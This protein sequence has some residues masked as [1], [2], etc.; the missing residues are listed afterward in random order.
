MEKKA[1]YVIFDGECGFCNSSALW[2]AKHDVD[3]DFI[4][5]SNVSAFGQ[6]LLKQQGLAQVSPHSIILIDPHD[7]VFFKSR[8]I[9]KILAPL[10]GFSFLKILMNLTPLFLQNLVYDGIARFR[11]SIPLGKSCEI[12]DEELRKRFRL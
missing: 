12:P 1:S 7:A 5:V 8:A 9:K 3:H 11:K 4:L 6:K 2:I 10:R